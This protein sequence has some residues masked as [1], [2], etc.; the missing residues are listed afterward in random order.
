MVHAWL[1]QCNRCIVCMTLQQHVLSLPWYISRQWSYIIRTTNTIFDLISCHTCIHA[2]WCVWRIQQCW[3]HTVAHMCSVQLTCGD[4]CCIALTDFTYQVVQIQ[5]YVFDC[6]CACW[7]GRPIHGIF[8]IN[9]DTSR[10][11]S[12]LCLTHWQ[13]LVV[14]HT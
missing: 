5:I 3:Q 13:P 14:L 12:D 10:I 9:H 7:H 2:D 8:D 4:V 11:I 1:S 6:L